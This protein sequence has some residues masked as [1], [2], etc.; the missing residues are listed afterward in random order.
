MNVLRTI[1]QSIDFPLKNL[2]K[3]KSHPK[4]IEVK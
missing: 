2:G 1:I 4:V 3:S